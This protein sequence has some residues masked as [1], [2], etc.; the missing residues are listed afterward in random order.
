MGLNPETTT[1][2]PACGPKMKPGTLRPASP[3]ERPLST[4]HLYHFPEDQQRH[5]M[6][7]SSLVPMKYFRYMFESF[8]AVLNK[9]IKRFRGESV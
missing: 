1:Q 4:C 5:H 2:V 8:E 7:S 9:K 3:P 6:F